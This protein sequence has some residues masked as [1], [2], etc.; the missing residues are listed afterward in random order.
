MIDPIH[1]RELADSIAADMRAE[2]REDDR[3]RNIADL[4]ALKAAPY[5]YVGECKIRARM[6]SEGDVEWL[7][8]HR[9]SGAT[10][11]CQDEA[12][13]R[14]WCAEKTNPTARTVTP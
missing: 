4:A 12:T 9:P 11:Y 6:N 5:S 10:K 7:A 3:N 14:A 8:T 2:R 13:A 1:D